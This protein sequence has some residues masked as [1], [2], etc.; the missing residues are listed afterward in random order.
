[1]KWWEE[2]GGGGE[3]E[4]VNQLKKEDSGLPKRVRWGREGEGGALETTM[5]ALTQTQF[6]LWGESVYGGEGE[7]RLTLF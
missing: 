1:M 5:P 7:V 2:G 6:L 3:E 4:E